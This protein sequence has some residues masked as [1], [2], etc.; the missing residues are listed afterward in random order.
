MK[1]HRHGCQQMD[2]LWST[3]MTRAWPLSSPAALC[4]HPASLTPEPAEPSLASLAGI[5]VIDID[6]QADI[7]L[8]IERELRSSHDLRF[9]GWLASPEQLDEVIAAERRHGFKGRFAIV[10]DHNIPGF[11]ACEVIAGITHRHP[12]ANII[13]FTG[14]VHGCNRALA[15]GV[16][17]CISK[18]ASLSDLTTAIRAA[19]AA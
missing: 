17:A 13:I 1:D 14:D 8:V 11:D 5:A 4:D 6:D 3:P 15:A 18:D 12:D 10:L 7:G 19:G 16:S 9:A 2:F